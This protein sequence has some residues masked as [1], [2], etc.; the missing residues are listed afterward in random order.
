MHPRIRQIA[1]PLDVPHR[2]RGS[3][4]L[5][6]MVAAA[7]LITIMSM[8]VPVLARSA[9]KRQEIDQREQAL[10][11]VS[12][13][14]EHAALQSPPSRESLQ[15]IADQCIKNSELTNPEWKIVVTPEQSPPMNRVE[16][17]LSW[18]SRPHV[19]SSATLVRWYRGGTP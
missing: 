6:A 9:E 18:Q 10:T 2:R 7:L 3:A 8:L 11:A 12:N 19:R 15:P 13:L 4:L 14:L 5:E 16:A 17:T 1:I